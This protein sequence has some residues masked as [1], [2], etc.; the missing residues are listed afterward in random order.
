M[1]IVGNSLLVLLALPALLS[2]SY[3]IALTLLSGKPQVPRAGVPRLRFDLIVPAHNEAPLIARTIKSL[4]AV[5]WPQDQY[6]II[7]VADNCTDETARVAEAAGAE[8]ITRTDP[9]KRGKGYAVGFAFDSSRDQGWADAVVIV[10]ADSEVSSNILAAFAARIE[11]GVGAVQVHYGVRNTMKSWRTR[12]LTIATTSFTIVRSRARE[13]LNL[14]CGIRGNGW[15]V[16][17]WL[18]DR[19]PYHA[20]SLA[21]DVEYGIDLGLE[22]YRVAYADEAHAYS[23]M[24]SNEAIARVQR[25]RWEDGRF[26]LIRTK[27]YSLF[28]AAIKRKSKVPLD[29]GVDLLV[30]PIAYVTLNTLALAVIA[31]ASYQLHWT[32]GAFLWIAVGCSASLTV[33]VCRGWQLSGVGLRGAL[34]LAGAPWFLMWKIVVHWGRRK[35]NEWVRTPRERD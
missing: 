6:R 23:D 35:S 28:A 4:Q 17:H 19:V 13:R 15:C 27:A 34:D 31:T 9:S 18:L 2:C 7:V 5:D 29:L 24:V 16:T 25:R 22:G 12:L 10:D 26:Q 20:Y 3:L 33:H 8:V 1:T 32:S 14:S 21:E 30:L 11:A